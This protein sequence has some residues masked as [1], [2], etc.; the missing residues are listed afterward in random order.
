[1]K[2]KPAFHFKKFSIV[3]DNSS[4]KLNT[5]GVLLGAWA[6]I[7]NGRSVLDI[8]TGTGIIALMIAQRS[9][10]NAQIIGIDT[11][12]GACT[13]AITNVKNSPNSTSIT[14]LNQ[15][16]QEFHDRCKIKFDLIVSNPPFF[17]DGTQSKNSEKAQARHTITLPH[18][19]L[20]QLVVE[21]L[22]TSGR[23]CVILP[24]SEGLKFVQ[25][26]N[27]YGLFADRIT[28][29]MSKPNR[30]IERML[31]SFSKTQLTTNV[32]QLTMRTEFDTE[33]LT[34][35]TKEYKELTKDFYLFGSSKN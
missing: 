31:I 12:K 33:H 1:M 18:I 25:N 29:V 30:P 13:D 5:D 35:Y 2:S 9:N 21:L 6:S 14:I 26:A 15:S 32:N 19:Q 27:E 16:L 22:S 4:M 24:H 34:D 10:G 28:E 3:Q 11:D 23:F 20:I 17:T 7:D 8:G